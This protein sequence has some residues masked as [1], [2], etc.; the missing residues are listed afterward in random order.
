MKKDKQINSDIIHIE[1]DDWD[2]NFESEKCIHIFDNDNMN[3]LPFNYTFTTV[4]MAIFFLITTTEEDLKKYGYEELLEFKVDFEKDYHSFT[5][6]FYPEYNPA[7]WFSKDENGKYFDSMKYY[8][9]IY[10]FVDKYKNEMMFTTNYIIKPIKIQKHLELI[11]NNP[12]RFNDDEYEVVTEYLKQNK[13]LEGKGWYSTLQIK[14]INGKDYK[15][16]IL[17]NAIALPT[18]FIETQTKQKLKFEDEPIIWQPFDISKL[19]IWK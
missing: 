16:P 9:T 1:I 14:N 8:K 15:I 10:L 3:K 6:N 13:Q 2:C 18:G 12:N 11:K 19:E 4:D 7:K 17:E 5:K